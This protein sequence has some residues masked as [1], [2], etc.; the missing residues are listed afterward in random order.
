M[1]KLAWRGRKSSADTLNSRPHLVLV[2]SPKERRLQ[3][4]V[5]H[6]RDGTPTAHF[7]LRMA[8]EIR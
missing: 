8:L 5:A 7:S 2:Q 3:S 1:A 6:R 4:R